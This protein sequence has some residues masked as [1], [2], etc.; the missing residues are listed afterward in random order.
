MLYLSLS[1]L[2][3]LPSS[4]HADS[5]THYQ[6]YLV[7][8]R[9]AGMG[10]AFVALANEATGAYYNPAGIISEG[11][12][13]IQLSMSAYKLRH[14]KVQVA[15]ICGTPISDDDDA[16][17]GFPG[18]LG[19]VH[20][21]RTG[22]VHHGLGL[23]VVVPYW[24]RSSQI[25]TSGD[26]KIL[27]SERTLTVG[28]SQMLVDRVFWGGISYA[29]KP[30]RFLQFGATAGFSIRSYSYNVLL[31]LVSDAENSFPVIA[32]HNMEAV[33]WSFFAQ[34]GVIITP[35]SGLRLGLTFTSPYV[36]IV[37]DGR[38]DIIYAAGLAQDRSQTGGLVLEEAEAYWEV[39][40]RL[41]LGAAYTHKKRFSVALDVTLHGPVD[42]YP[43]LRNQ[44]LS[45]A[46]L[47]SVVGHNRRDVV[48]N[49]NLG[50]EVLVHR[51]LALRL[52]FFTNLSSYPNEPGLDD[53][54]HVQKFGFTLGATYR[55]TRRS[56]LSL[57]VQGQVGQL[58][59]TA[60]RIKMGA[61]KTPQYDEFD[62][63]ATDLSLILSVGGSFDI[64]Q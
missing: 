52:G 22:E 5:D 27:C 38:T 58:N 53:F 11:S 17:F 21:F 61:L 64:R 39:P 16:F 47:T 6:D 8:E 41:S 34:V 26:K 25:F 20:Q 63:E 3:S 43:V 13:L 42:S 44:L 7:G 49:V 40:F 28:G 51:K 12:T 55:S 10:G 24:D 57:A 30:W 31:S 59:T 50:T 2:V 32:F 36:R 56:A 62:V 14:R 60:T 45:D 35:V 54:D 9:A 29:I 4:S 46:G 1:L 19:F 18:S 37:G 15:D 48:V 33:L 23:T